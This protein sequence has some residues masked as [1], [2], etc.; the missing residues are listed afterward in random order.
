MCTLVR[1]A[2]CASL[3][4]EATPATNTP[5][6]SERFENRYRSAR[7]L[8]SEFLEQYSENGKL[9]RAAAGTTY[10][11]KPGKMRWEYEKPEKNLFLVDGKTAW[12]YTPADHTATRVPAR[13]SEDWRTPFALLAGEMKLSRVC[14]RVSATTVLAPQNPEDAMLECHLKGTD[15]APAS[16]PEGSP[17]QVFFEISPGGELVRLLLRAAG[18]I[19]TEFQFKNWEINPQVSDSLFQFSPPPGVVI[20]DGLLP[21]SSRIRQ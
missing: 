15:R 7:T 21:S 19:Q 5:T 14:S 3:L 2:I 12:L 4:L 11:R 1:L 8:R 9:V 16:N 10:F 13:E 20:V 6:P 18:G 17:P